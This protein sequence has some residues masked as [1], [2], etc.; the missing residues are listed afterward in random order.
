M[1]RTKRHNYKVGSIIVYNAFGGLRRRVKVEEKERDIKNGRPGFSG[2]EVDADGKPLGDVDH[3]VW[4]YDDQ[5][6][7]VV[8][9]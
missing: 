6:I 2:I 3:G 1:F 8:K 5:I 9:R 7:R 4:G